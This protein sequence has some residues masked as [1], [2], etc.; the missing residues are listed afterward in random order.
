MKRCPECGQYSED[1]AS[2][3]PRCGCI[4]PDRQDVPDQVVYAPVCKPK[5]NG[6]SVGTVVAVV[7]VVAILLAVSISFLDIF[8]ASSEYKDKTRTYSWT[9]PSIDDSP[10][11][12]VSLDISGEEMR[13]ADTSTIDRS[14]SSTNVSNPSQGIHAVRE[15]VVVSDTI[16]S[17]SSKLWDEYKTQIVE[18]PGYAAY[19]N[20]RYFADY[21]LAFVQEAADY[22]YDSR[23]F[24]QEEYWQYPVET[25]YRGYGDCEDTSIL[26]S[27]IYSHLSTMDGAKDWILGASVLL[28]PGHAMVGVDV[29]GGLT[30]MGLYKIA[31]G[32]SEHYVGE[33]TI[34]DP[35][36]YTKISW[37]H[38]GKLNDMYQGSSI[39]AFQ[40]TS[41]SY[42]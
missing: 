10:T 8:D 32:S 20:A 23:E 37:W 16:I 9:V 2:F 18:K 12:S 28:L 14:G 40:G 30:G 34:D 22:A 1:D 31:V 13:K 17:L 24:G 19:A 42:A 7:A 15:Y 38:V 33:T 6:P 35:G 4:L 26:A 3:C 27:A 41:S 11:F 5:R 21:I 29:Y 39:L 36:S 25:L